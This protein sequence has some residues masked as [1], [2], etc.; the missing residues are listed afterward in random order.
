MKIHSTEASCFPSFLLSSWNLRNEIIRSIWDHRSSLG[1][2]AVDPI[3]KQELLLSKD[4]LTKISRDF[5]RP[6]RRKRR[7]EGRVV[8][9]F[10]RITNVMPLEG[11]FSINS[12]IP[13]SRE[14]FSSRRGPTAAFGE[15]I[16]VKKNE[17]KTKA[18]KKRGREAEGGKK[19]KELATKL[20]HSTVPRFFFF[21]LFSFTDDFSKLSFVR[22]VSDAGTDGGFLFQQRNAL[23]SCSSPRIFLSRLPSSASICHYA[24]I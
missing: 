6:P 9:L 24:T 18:K 20:C 5:R 1:F 14:L 19:S 17:R 23:A 12:T 16:R 15:K 7:E 21:L 8:E 22:R 3:L 13:L 10:P 4:R 11:T 2:R